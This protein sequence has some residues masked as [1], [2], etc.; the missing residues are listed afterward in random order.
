[1]DDWTLRVPARMAREA[2]YGLHSVLGQSAQDISVITDRK[3]R[4]GYPEWYREPLVRFDR[5]RGLLDLFSWG[6]PARP[7]DVLLD[8]REHGWA[9]LKG[10]EVAL[11]V[12]DDDLA[13][14]G[15]VDEERRARQEPPV[16]GETVLR[17]FAL[18][19]YVT[20][21][22]EHIDRLGSRQ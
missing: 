8:V 10:L 12:G 18:R 7:G 16:E 15:R 4:E 21:V 3:G 1:M 6:D 22:Q 20:A 2:R 11:I 5:A 13:E 9:L 14:A 19:E 17:V